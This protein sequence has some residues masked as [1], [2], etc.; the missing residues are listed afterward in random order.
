MVLCNKM[1]YITVSH[2][3]RPKTKVLFYLTIAPNCSPSDYYCDAKP[4][5]IIIPTFLILNVKYFQSKVEISICYIL[6]FWKITLETVDIK[7]ICITYFVSLCHKCFTSCRIEIFGFFQN[8]VFPS[9]NLYPHL[10]YTHEFF[11]CFH[12]SKP[13]NII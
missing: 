13:V 6:Y 2:K 11:M 7:R 4:I 3:N 8:Y 9:L 10:F 1:A 12:K 5:L